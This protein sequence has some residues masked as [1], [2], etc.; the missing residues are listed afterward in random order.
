MRAGA[1]GFLLKD[2]PEAQLVAAIQ[3]VA[4]GGSLFAPHA[5]RRVIE[6]FARSRPVPP[7]GLAELDASRAR[8]AS[9]ASPGAVRTTRSPS[10]LGVSEHTAKTH[11]AHILDKLGLRD[12]V[13]A[14]VLAY[15]AGVVRPGDDPEDASAIDGAAEQGTAARPRADA[16]RARQRRADRHAGSR[17]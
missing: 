7:P 9:A 11:V 10:A 12:R 2:A 13:Q 15:E 16:C 14:V 8:G 1:S 5:T 6:A 17:R 3:V 4:S